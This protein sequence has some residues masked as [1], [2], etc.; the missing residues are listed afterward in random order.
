MM[1]NVQLPPHIRSLVDRRAESA[2]FSA[3]KRAA[4]A[5]SDAYRGGAAAAVRKLPA[6]ER[7]AAYMVT[8]MPAT[9]A[10]AWRVLGEVRERLGERPVESILD[11]GA[12]TGAASLAARHWFPDASLT[13]LE[14]DGAFADAARE[15]LPGA[16]MRMDD[17]A[18]LEAFPPHDLVVA[19]YSL[20][21]L[22][23]DVVARL[24][25]AARVALVVIEP[26]T[27]AGFARIREIRGQLLGQDARMIAPCPAETPCPLAGPDWCHFAARVERSSLHR[28]VKDAGLNYEDEKFSYVALG[29][30]PAALPGGRIIRRPEHRPGLVVLEI[31][32][33]SGTGVERVSR[34]G[35]AAFKAARAAAWGDAWDPGPDPG[36]RLGGVKPR[37][38]PPSL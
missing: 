3:L 11:V 33:A 19:A 26:G 32:R 18:R 22:P 28:R 27:P 31:C 13:L 7:A 9:Y 24:W 12:G 20:N 6:A 5:M 15:C 35:R 25:R 16:A 29:R 34:H 17:A 23:P 4:A 14:R 21:E 30:A 10:V 37:S 1:V 8:R 2:G 38:G 36:P